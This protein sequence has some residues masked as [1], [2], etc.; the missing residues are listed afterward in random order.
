MQRRSGADC[1]PES[2][3]TVTWIARILGGRGSR[4]DRAKSH[5]PKTRPTRLYL[6]SLEE[7][8]LLATTPAP[9]VPPPAP[10]ASVQK[11]PTLAINGKSA[12]TQQSKVWQYNSNWWMVMGDSGDPAVAGSGGTFL[13]RLDGNKWTQALKLNFKKYNA[14]VKVVGNL[15]QVLLFGTDEGRLVSLEYVPAV[16]PAP[17]TYQVWTQHPKTTLVSL[18]PPPPAGTIGAAAVVNSAT[19][20]VDCNGRIWL[21]S[22][23]FNDI[24]VRYSDAPYTTFSDPILLATN[25]SPKDLAVVTAMPNCKMGVLWTNHVT[26]R[27]GFRTH[28]SQN[29][30]A[31]NWTADEVPAAQSAQRSGAGM[32]GTAMNVK[33]AADG[34]LYAAVSTGFSTLDATLPQVGLLVR[35]SGGWD[36]LNKVDSVGVHPIVML[37]ETAGIV[38]VAYTVLDPLA[39]AGSKATGEIAYSESPTSAISFAPRKTLFAGLHDDVTSTKQNWTDSVMV[40]ASTRTNPPPSID[41]TIPTPPATGE[42]VSAFLSTSSKPTSANKAPVVNA[43]TDVTTPIN[44]PATLKGKIKDDKLPKVPGKVTSAWSMLSGPGTVTFAKPASTSTTAAFSAAGTYVLRL[45]A[46][47]GELSASDDVQVIVTPPPANK[48]P[49]VNAG[50]DQELLAIMTTSL[51]GS[52]KDDGQ[53]LPVKLTSKWSQV[54][55]P[56]SVTFASPA[57]ASTGVTFGAEGTYVLRLEANDGALTASDDVQVI[58][59]MVPNAA[60]IVNAGADQSVTLTAGATLKATAT[61][62]GLPKPTGTLKTTWSQV[63]GPA[64]AAFKSTSALS[65]TVKFKTAGTYVFRLTADDGLLKTT[66]DVSIIVA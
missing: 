8:L 45:Q 30:D 12:D 23:G 57:A 1:S 49:V 39:A 38:D 31:T 6:E 26:Q 18:A 13:W 43:G 3:E 51:P 33:V 34:T 42:V 27:F 60:P 48:A 20:D 50:A 7:R 40:F 9:P 55:G 25:T 54:S 37:N 21:A 41:P 47:D 24:Q 4:A 62:D 61:D 63:S 58:V 65:T 66:D 56:G 32:A 35:R 64:K 53:P 15:A 52:V 59:R 46:S 36:P 29:P 14:D 28:D 11:L 44:L 19:I 5:R 2:S 17:A 10:V 16:A 22:D